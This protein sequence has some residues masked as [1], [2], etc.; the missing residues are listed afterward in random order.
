MTR[1]KFGVGIR[2]L[3][4]ICHIY[5]T[6]HFVRKKLVY[7][8]IVQPATSFCFRTEHTVMALLVLIVPNALSWQKGSS[9]ALIPSLADYTIRDLH[10]HWMHNK[11]LTWKLETGNMNVKCKC[12]K[13]NMNMEWIGDYQL[14]H[15]Y[16]VAC[17]VWLCFTL[18]SYTYFLWCWVHAPYSHTMYFDTHDF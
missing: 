8:N 6:F 10:V 17:I 18:H 5:S 4:L 2:M 7:V 1:H 14:L 13:W 15:R 9:S 3:R 12:E 11:N 16:W